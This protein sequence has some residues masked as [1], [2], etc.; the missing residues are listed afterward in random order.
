MQVSMFSNL[1]CFKHFLKGL[2]EVTWKP[3]CILYQKAELSK[4]I[5][6]EILQKAFYFSIKYY[7]FLFKLRKSLMYCGS[8]RFPRIKSLHKLINYVYKVI[9]PFAGS[10]IREH[11]K[12]RPHEPVTI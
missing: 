9:F 6:I 8:V 5:Q 11:M 2:L 1:S 12:L 10:C 4:V 3:I 7:V